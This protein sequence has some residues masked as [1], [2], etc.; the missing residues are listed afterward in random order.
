MDV[1]EIKIHDCEN[2]HAEVSWN[3]SEP[4]DAVLLVHGDLLLTHLTRHIVEDF[5]GEEDA[6]A[7]SSTRDQDH[8]EE[9]SFAAIQVV[10]LG[11]D[12]VHDEENTIEAE[13][14][15]QR[16]EED[17]VLVVDAQQGQEACGDYHKDADKHDSSF[18]SEYTTAVFMIFVL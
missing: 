17:K 8:K 2:D 1:G 16:C 6:I 13:N 4:T 7:K 18:K 12:L 10:L 11:N 5:V 14:C 15:N 9:E 3:A